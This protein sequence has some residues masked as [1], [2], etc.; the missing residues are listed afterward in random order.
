MASENKLFIFNKF[1]KLVETEVLKTNVSYSL[2]NIK[3]DR[4]KNYDIAIDNATK[5]IID[6]Q[7][8]NEKTYSV[9][10]KNTNEIANGLENRPFFEIEHFINVLYC[11]L[12][13]DVYDPVCNKRN[14]FSYDGLV[15]Y[16]KTFH[17]RLIE[18][19]LNE[20][21]Q[22]YYESLD[23]EI[24]EDIFEILEIC[25][26]DIDIKLPKQFEIYI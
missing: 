17:D 15:N 6:F 16:T 11:D 26:I 12:L 24:L 8:T 25:M 2:S 14:R 10:S 22:K 5:T 4:Y 1:F 13:F 9:I 18:E 23:I 7:K 20:K 19:A 3:L 21:E